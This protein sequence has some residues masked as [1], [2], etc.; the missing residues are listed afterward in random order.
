M[1]E[2]VNFFGVCSYVT[3]MAPRLYG[4]VDIFS[5]LFFGFAM[6]SFS[7]ILVDWNLVGLKNDYRVGCAG[8]IFRFFLIFKILDRVGCNSCVR[9]VSANVGA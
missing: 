4:M 3:A 8:R 1:F 6:D 2:N 7:S 9:R 5:S